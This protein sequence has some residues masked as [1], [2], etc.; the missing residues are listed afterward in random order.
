[1]LNGVGAVVIGS[2]VEVVVGIAVVVSSTTTCKAS[3]GRVV[4][5]GI[6]PLPLAA[7]GA[8]A[9]IAVD[10]AG[11]TDVEG[12]TAGAKARIGA[13][14]TAAGAKVRVGAGPLP[15]RGCVGSSFAM[16]IVIDWPLAFTVIE[17][18]WLATVKRGS[19]GLWLS[20]RGDGVDATVKAG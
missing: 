19:T 18:P 5:N 14:P 12:T 3:T 1:V 13:G 6:A 15:S 4:C 9:T 8:A 2:A 20:S 17:V 16:L 11:T 10:A 7:G